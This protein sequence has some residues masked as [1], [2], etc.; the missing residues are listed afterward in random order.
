MTGSNS[1]EVDPKICEEGGKGLFLP[2]E[3]EQTWDNRVRAVIYFLMISWCFLGVSIIADIFMAAIETITSKRVTKKLKNGQEVV[4]KVWN[5]TVAN[6]TLMALGSSAPEILLSIIEIVGND[7]YSGEL[8]PS[9][10]VGSAAFNLLGIS[11]VCVSSIP[12]GEVR[13]VKRFGP[14]L[15]T[16]FWSVFAYFWV[17]FILAVTSPDKVDLWEG[18]ITFLFFPLFVFMAFLADIGVCGHREENHDAHTQFVVDRAAEEGHQLDAEDIA[19]LQKACKDEEHRTRAAH[20]METSFGVMSKPRNLRSKELTVGFACTRYQFPIG[21]DRMVLHLQKTGGKAEES[22]LGLEIVTKEGRAR[23]SESARVQFAGYAEIP[24]GDP[25]ASIVITAAGLL[26]APELVE[27]PKNPAGRRSRVSV[28]Q[29]AKTSSLSASGS[30]TKN[31]AQKVFSLNPFGYM[32]RNDT[33]KAS[34]LDVTTARFQSAEP[35]NLTQS[36]YFEIEVTKC[37][38]LRS[39]AISRSLEEEMTSPDRP[40][41]PVANDLIRVDVGG[42]KGRGRLSFSKIEIKVPAHD[43]DTVVRLTVQ[44]LGGADG[45]VVCSWSTEPDSARPGF[46]FVDAEGELIFPPGGTEAF[47]EVTVLAKGSWE[48]VERFFVVLSDI[49]ESDEI[50]SEENHTCCIVLLDHEGSLTGVEKMLKILDKGVNIDAFSQGNR[51]WLDQF[52]NACKPVPGDDEEARKAQPKDWAIHVISFPWKIFFACVPPTSY[53]G[54]WLCFVSALIFIGICT[55]IIGDIAALLGCVL[56]L[57][58]IIT[59]STI[60]AVGTSLPDTMASKKAAID[61]PTADNALGNITGSNA[62]NVFLGLGLPWMIAAIFWQGT[63][64]EKW[65]NKYPDLAVKYPDGGFIVVAGDL[66]FAV[67]VFLLASTSCIGVILLRRK[68]FG[69]ELGGASGLKITTSLFF[70]LLWVFYISLLTWKVNTGE[71]SGGMQVLAVFVG[72]VSVMV[73]MFVLSLV[74]H[75]V[76]MYS[77]HKKAAM[78]DL[79]HGRSFGMDPK[80]GYGA[81]GYDMDEKMTLKECVV[82]LTHQMKFLDNRCKSLEKKLRKVP[83]RE[84]KRRPEN[85]AASGSYKNGRTGTQLSEVT[86]TSTDSDN[87]TASSVRADLIGKPA[88]KE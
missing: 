1:T 41:V 19:L 46:D 18:I 53:C 20:R 76:N 36:G 44:R 40:V 74:H 4:V 87:S 67:N 5:A 68:A 80:L 30:T 12:D 24:E 84:R 50:V 32:H 69:A 52:R 13:T 39:K 58:D 38:L 78:K 16:A 55:A 86:E 47:I 23:D 31:L 35:L 33:E 81:P 11:A 9:A 71:V 49:D 14:F 62:V 48:N 26:D 6:L 73:V 25:T 51:E 37:K 66:S 65:M 45:E 75:F 70:L 63:M 29:K 85:G 57:P 43:A 72:F 79:L 34:M 7:M 83:D 88:V 60:V 8:G 15:V 54:G 17:M 10:I 56:D 42:Q 28:Q 27:A 3:Y 61:E 64:P 2:F 59:A 82:D 77:D 21:T 22:R